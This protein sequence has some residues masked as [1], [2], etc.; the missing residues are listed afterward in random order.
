MGAAASPIVID[1]VVVVEK[2]H[3]DELEGKLFI[4]SHQL[5]ELS[6]QLIS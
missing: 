2:K 6:L 4:Q 1:Q 3:R 5:S